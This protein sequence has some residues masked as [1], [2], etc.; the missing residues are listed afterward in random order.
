MTDRPTPTLR[1]WFVRG[2]IV[3]GAMFVLL[4]LAVFSVLDGWWVPWTPCPVPHPGGEPRVTFKQKAAHPFLA[5]YYYRVEFDGPLGSNEEWLRMNT[6][7]R[8]SFAVHWFPATAD[9]GPSLLFRPA[10]RS[11]GARDCLLRLDEQKTY[12]IVRH[13]GRAYAGRLTEP[14]GGHGV[15]KTIYQDGRPPEVEVRI[16]GADR[17]EDV[18]DQLVLDRSRMLG[19]IEQ[20]Q[21]LRF[22]PTET[23][24]TGTPRQ[25]P[26][27]R[28][29]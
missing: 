4:L 18:T 21:G 20:K 22:V 16:D 17:I 11:S 25:P 9:H 29:R 26:G 12:L 3:I 7:G 2:L 6:G 1:K 13:E 8:T 5:E 15:S 19:T 27:D 28:S 10:N 14:M 23:T 24:P